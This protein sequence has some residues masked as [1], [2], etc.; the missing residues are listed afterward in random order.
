MNGRLT[1]VL[2]VDGT[3]IED[4]VAMGGVAVYGDPFEPHGVGVEED[5]PDI[6]PGRG[7]GKIDGF[8]NRIVRVALKCR[9][10]L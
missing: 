4:L 6:F 8:G 1:A 10:D 7:A 9:L 5:L 2:P 3:G